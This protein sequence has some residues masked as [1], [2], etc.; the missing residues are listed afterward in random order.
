MG[1]F[2]NF[3]NVVNMIYR[4][5]AIKELFWKKYAIDLLFFWLSEEKIINILRQYKLVA[6]ELYEYNKDKIEKYWIIKILIDF[7]WEEIRLL[8]NAKEI[9]NE[10]Y[11]LSLIG[12]DI[13]NINYVSEEKK[14][15]ST[16]ISDTLK[17][18]K[19]KAQLW[20]KEQ[21]SNVEQNR[22]KN[23]EIFDDQ[24]LEKTQKL[25]R[26][27]LQ[28]IPIFI[29]KAKDTI[30]KNELKELYAQQQELSKLEMWSNVEK[31]SSYIE[32]IYANYSR[33]EQEFLSIQDSPNIDISGSN[34]SEAY[35]ASEITKLEKAKSLQK[36]WWA[37]KWDD[38]LYANFWETFL[39]F[40]LM[41]K[42]IISKFKNFS[43]DFNKIFWYLSLS[44]CIIT[45]L[46]TIYIL[47]INKNDISFVV[48]IYSSV[49]WL[50]LFCTKFIK[51]ESV[52]SNVLSLI[53]SILISVL[54]II[55]LK[56]LF[57]F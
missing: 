31:I 52:F 54:I 56:Q 14:I 50:I 33:L 27:L 21:N 48:M 23:E 44:F 13:K 24:K 32:T 49:F 34:V 4:V 19:E 2:R 17:T 39:Y 3:K 35:L 43:L 57:I 18:E 29:E 9:E 25:A 53:W 38:A 10:I 55:F 1:I 20:I 22:K 42:D 5:I 41:K 7:E 12:F 40:R 30:S 36:L 26:E 6:L 47:T 45:L 51:K 28:K 8:T 11:L 16:V 37:K 15:E 46:S